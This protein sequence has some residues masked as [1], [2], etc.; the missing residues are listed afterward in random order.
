MGVS[1]YEAE[2]AT[3]CSRSSALGK[4]TVGGRMGE[5]ENGSEKRVRV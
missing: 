5:E 4:A 2:E 3:E 1:G